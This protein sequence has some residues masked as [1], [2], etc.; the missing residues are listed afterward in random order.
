MK[1]IGANSLGKPLRVWLK[2]FKVQYNIE[3]TIHLA[4]H[5]VQLQKPQAS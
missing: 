4:A 5:V 3:N 2:P 1:E